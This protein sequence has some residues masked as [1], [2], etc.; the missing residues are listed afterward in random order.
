M[1]PIGIDKH[2]EG[3][4]PDVVSRIEPNVG[5]VENMHLIAGISS[6][7]PMPNDV[8]QMNFWPANG[9]TSLVFVSLHLPGWF[10]LHLFTPALALDILVLS[11]VWGMVFRHSGSLWSCI[12]SH[13]A[14]DFIS[15]V[16]FHGR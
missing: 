8:T 2:F 13:S 10:M 3:L 11:F 16:L 4:P 6:K 7:R 12:I 5:T 1:R 15:F 9:L 14:N